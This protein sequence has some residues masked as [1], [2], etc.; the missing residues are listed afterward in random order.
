MMQCRMCSQRL[1]RPGKLCRECERELAR[2]RHAA[3]SVE[4][5]ATSI[6]EIE[7][8]QLVVPS[9]VAAWR[10]RGMRVPLVVAA[11]C[12][13]IGAT[14][15]VYTLQRTASA[16]AGESVM[17]DRDSSRVQPRT[18]APR[19][20]RDADDARGA[21]RPASTAAAMQVREAPKR[22]L[23]AVSSAS[24]T[25]APARFDRVLGLSDAFAQCATETFFSRLA[26]EQR[27]RAR[28]CE[29]AAGRL[30]QCPEEARRDYGQ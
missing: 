14:A 20:P 15:A 22:R 27:A 8:D 7:T 21:L 30:P 17:L 24:G 6:P 2:A 29:G 4:G 1:T 5:L 11:F 10:L 13:G 12:L 28:Y 16:D 26:C 18:F 23:V 9:M 25:E 3:A 19:M